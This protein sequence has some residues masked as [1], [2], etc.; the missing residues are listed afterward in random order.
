M[1][2]PDVKA[3]Y[4]GVDADY[5]D[6]RV[7]L[8]KTVA[9]GWN[10]GAA[11]IGAN[12]DRYWRPPVCALSMA[13]GDTRAVNRSAFI[14]RAGRTFCV[15]KVP[16]GAW[17]AVGRVAAATPARVAPPTATTRLAR[18]GAAAPRRTCP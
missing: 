3:R 2:H 12:N 11:V 1:G 9:R 8:T 6:W 15:A 14:V 13:N 18:C 16:I 5:S 4:A 17:R 10:V 7:A